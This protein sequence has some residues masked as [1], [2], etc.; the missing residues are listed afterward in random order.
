[1]RPGLRV[2]C[3]NLHFC[4]GPIRLLPSPAILPPICNQSPSH[5]ILQNVFALSLEPFRRSQHVIKRLFLPDR[6][7]SSQPEVDS[8]PRSSLDRPHNL[9]QRKYFAQPLVHQRRED[10]VNMIRHDDRDIEFVFVA[11]MWQHDDSAISRAQSGR[12]HR[13]FVTNVTKCA[14]KSR[15]KC[16]RF[17]RK[18]C[19]PKF[20]HLKR[21][22]KHM[23]TKNSF[24][25]PCWELTQPT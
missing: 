18:N 15:C 22:A 12:I 17:R 9:H 23:R 25:F 8:T 1:M 11:M 24:R 4:D 7:M 3:L 19:M 16:G 10:Q 6:L 2:S 5:R 13:N 20:C 21:P 14:L